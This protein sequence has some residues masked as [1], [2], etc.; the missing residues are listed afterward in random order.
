MS[1]QEQDKEEITELEKQRMSVA[2]LMLDYIASR[3]IDLFAEE[4]YS[5]L[6]EDPNFAKYVAV[7]SVNRQWNIS[8]IRQVETDK[9]LVDVVN[10]NMPYFDI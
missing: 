4:W 7:P 2:R 6:K 9:D 1:Y 8:L 5:Y 3:E 10:R